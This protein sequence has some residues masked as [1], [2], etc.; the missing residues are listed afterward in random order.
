MS[1]PEPSARLVLQR[2]RNRIIEDLE[3]FSSFEKQRDYAR[4]VPICYVPYELIDDWWTWVETPRP[5]HFVDP[6]FTSLERDAVERFHAA[7]DEAA[8][9][10]PDN[11][12]PL[13][14]VLN[15]DY[16]ARLRKSAQE[17]LAVFQ[18]RGKLSE[19]VEFVTH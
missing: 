1:T 9:T 12:P 14:E 10:L 3:L 7:W 6:V 2:I 19:D 11:F 4:Q 13:E 8:A 17:A 18:I 15:A 16:W 5:A